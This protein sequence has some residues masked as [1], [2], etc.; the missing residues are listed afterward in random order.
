MT[1]LMFALFNLF[2]FF[3]FTVHNEMVIFLLMFDISPAVY[4]ERLCFLFLYMQI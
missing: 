2:A 3:F 1:Y 4:L